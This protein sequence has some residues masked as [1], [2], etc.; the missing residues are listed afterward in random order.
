MCLENMLKQAEAKAVYAELV[1]SGFAGFFTL[2]R[3]I[4]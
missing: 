4:L 3:R 2:G 1:E